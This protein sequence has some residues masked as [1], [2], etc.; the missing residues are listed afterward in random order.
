MAAKVKAA[1]LPVRVENLG[2]PAGVELDF[3]RE[4]LWARMDAPM[5]KKAVEVPVYLVNPN[6]M[7]VL[8]PPERLRFLDPKAV[9]RWAQRMRE[10]EGRGEGEERPPLWGLE[11][12]ISVKPGCSSWPREKHRG[13]GPSSARKVLPSSSAPSASWPGQGGQGWTPTWSRTRSTTTS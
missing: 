8:Y 12:T 2:S 4:K 5:G 11:A 6:Q 9:H 3:S 1:V 10:Q 7:D 13:Q